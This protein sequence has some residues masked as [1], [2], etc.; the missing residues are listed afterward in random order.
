MVSDGI[1]AS[2]SEAPIRAGVG[3][4]RL[5]YR[6]SRS[7]GVGPRGTLFRGHERGG[8]VVDD[9]VLNLLSD[10]DVDGLW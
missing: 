9:L 2:K 4:G 5:M 7:V 10:G 6:V 3:K 8:R 1:V